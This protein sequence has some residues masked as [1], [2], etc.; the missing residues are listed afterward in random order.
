MAL[1][2]PYKF[3][4]GG[5]GSDVIDDE[6]V[7]TETTY[8]SSKI[9]SLFE[10]PTKTFGACS[11]DELV[12]I[13]SKA[14][15]GELNPSNSWAIGDERTVSLSE[16]GTSSYIDET[17]AAQAVNLVIYHVGLYYDKNG[18]MVNFIVGLK[19]CLAEKGKMTTR[20]INTGSWDSCARRQW[21]NSVF[22]NAIPVTIRA[23]F[24][25][26]KTVTATERDAATTTISID[27]FALP[28]EKEVFGAKTYATQQEFNELTQFDYFKVSANRIKK[29]NGLNDSWWLRSPYAGDDRSFCYVS[30]SVEAGNTNARFAEGLTPFGCI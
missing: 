30:Q 24:K 6:N 27:Y 26:F 22:Y 14:D 11:D 29:I 15:A 8:S 25:Q 13:I 17:H 19:D 23:I 7:S 20:N 10:L 12:S 28:A 4:G 21:C 18:K 9:E 3:G 5:G 1:Y 2:F 16:M